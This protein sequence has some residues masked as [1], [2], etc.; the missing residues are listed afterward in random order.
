MVQVLVRRS[1]W[2]VLIGL[3]LIVSCKKDAASEKGQAGP[4]LAAT[5]RPQFELAVAAVEG[6]S[7]TFTFAG[8]VGEKS[9]LSNPRSLAADNDGNLYVADFGNDRIVRFDATGKEVLAF[10]KKGTAPGEY[11]SVWSVAV[12]AQGLVYMLDPRTGY[13]YVYSRDGKYQ[14]RVGDLGFYSPSGLAVQK[15]GTMVVA[16][17]G[18][19]RIVFVGTDGK[20]KGE[21]ITRAGQA[22]L[23]QP[24]DVSVDAKDGFHVHLAGGGEKGAGSLVNF[25][26]DGSVQSKVATVAVPSTSDTPR[27]AEG[28]DGKVY[29]I[30]VEQGRLLAYSADGKTFYAIKIEGMTTPFRKLAGIAVDKQGQIFVSDADANVIYKFTPAVRAAEPAAGAAPGAPK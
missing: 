17:T 13:V 2:P 28:S 16:D 4:D 9:K 29:L 11:Q 21:P 20:M 23:D 6:P 25:A 24:A 26:A 7:L 15:D 22:T 10:G 19:S 8:Q 18:G 14:K 3:L 30:D 27:T 1:I 12:D 5:A